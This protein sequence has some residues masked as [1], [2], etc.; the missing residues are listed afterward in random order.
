M[1][2]S[3]THWV[4]Q[5]LRISLDDRRDSLEARSTT[6]IWL[7]I[8]AIL[9]VCTREASYFFFIGMLVWLRWQ[10]FNMSAQRRRA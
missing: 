5:V 8:L 10:R 7:I 6:L 1:L 9:G 2:R 3:Y 4:V